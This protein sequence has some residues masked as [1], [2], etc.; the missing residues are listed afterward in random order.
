MTAHAIGHDEEAA[1]LVG[2]RV[3]AVFVAGADASNI[4]AGGYGK[5][6]VSGVVRRE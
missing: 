3:E 4:C 5:L 1:L 2:F 6:H